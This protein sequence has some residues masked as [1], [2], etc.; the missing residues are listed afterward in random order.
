MGALYEAAIER[1]PTLRQSRLATF[2]RCALSAH[3]EEEYRRDWYSHEAARGQIMHRAWAKCLLTMAEQ[4]SMTIP[5][6][7]ALAVLEETL[8]QHDID[9]EC[10]K[11]FRP[12]VERKEGKVY[13]S[14]GHE[15]GSAFV[16]LPFE[17]IKDMR[18]TMVKWANESA[19]D[20]GQLVD[21]ELRLS[22]PI[23]YQDPGGE[24]VDRTLTG[25]ID[26]LFVQGDE[27]DVAVVID[28]K[29]TFG[30]PAP[31]D[32]GFDGYFQQRMYGWLVFRNI[33]SVQKVVL[34]EV[35][36]RKGAHREAEVWRQD[37]EDV[38]AE[39]QALAER[40]DRSFAERNFPPSPGHHCQF[41]TRPSACPIFPGARGA[42][43]IEDKETAA[44]VARELTV[45]EAVVK[46]HKEG[47]SAW[48]SVHGSEEVSSHKG[49]R[50]WTHKD[51]TRTSRPS[52]AKM[53]EALA[54]QKMGVPLSLDKLYEKS[55]VTR[56]GLHALP[57]I[58]DSPDDA[59]LMN[60]LEE[61]VRRA[62]QS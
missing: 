19:F 4:E 42:G 27:D 18:W 10:P 31:A 16:N 5:T 49:R 55:T 25:Q 46:Q 62:Q 15:Y 29:D 54:A 35:Y 61:S 51:S 36:P 52:R 53:E 48:T 12:I 44:R 56:F 50:G 41:C 30:L 22:A 13:C 23:R 57:E 14:N 8:R 9:Q 20:I 26:A 2:D 59:K 21:V 38:E 6:A 3:F 58:D 34:R 24:Y 60:A 43:M 11:C 39:L 28:W 40:F 47:L 37:I 1:F 45:A 33:P 17:Q 7:E 32:L